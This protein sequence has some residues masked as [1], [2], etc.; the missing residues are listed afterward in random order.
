MWNKDLQTNSDVDNAS[1]DKTNIPDNLNSS[2]TTHV[3]DFFHSSNNK[4]DDKRVSE[5]IT[6]RIHDEFNDL[7][8]GIGCFEGMFLLQVK[9]G[10]HLYQAPPRWVAYVT[11][12][13][14]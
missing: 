7:F 10:S 8:S 5:T 3:P 13:R 12:A 4:K 11:T 2:K 9:E 1:G 14:C 6:S